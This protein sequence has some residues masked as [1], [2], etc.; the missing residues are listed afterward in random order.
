MGGTGTRRMHMTI[1]YREVGALATIELN[2]PGHV[3]ESKPWKRLDVE[4]AYNRL[5]DQFMA[6]LALLGN[7]DACV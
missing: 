6:E 7:I 5:H 4:L 2:M 3:I 1:T